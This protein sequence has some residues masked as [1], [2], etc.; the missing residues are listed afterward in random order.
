MECLLIDDDLTLLEVMGR[1]FERR[2]HHCSLASD[3]DSALARLAG[4]NATHA[5]LDLRLGEENGL[6]LIPALL[7][8]KPGLRIVVLTGFASIATAVEAIKLGA[9]HYLTKPADVDDILAAF[10]EGAGAAEEPVPVP[11]AEPT[12]LERTE[13][14]FIQRTLQAC[15]GNVSAAAKRLGMHRRTLQRK[16]QKRPS[17][18][19]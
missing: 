14:E 15:D 10:G 3:S 8:A 7:Q 6:K 16:L 2:G 5:V 17:G 11:P 18:L 1:A 13:W 4:S 19:R 12:S 9:H